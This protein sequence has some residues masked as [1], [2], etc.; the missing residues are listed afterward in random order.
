MPQEVEKLGQLPA[1]CQV[2]P[3]V[4]SSRSSST[5]SVQPSRVRWYSALQPTAPPPMTTTRAWLL[6]QH[7]VATGCARHA[8]AGAPDSTLHPRARGVI[9]GLQRGPRGNALGGDLHLVS[10]CG[11]P[12]GAHRCAAV[13]EVAET[14]R[15]TEGM[16]EHPGGDA[17][18]QLIVPPDRLVVIQQAIGAL[19][20]NRHESPP[21]ALRAPLAERLETDKA[22][23]LVPGDGEL[24]AGL[25]RCV[26]VADVVAPVPIRLFHAQAVQGMVARE[27]QSEGLTRTDDHVVYGL[28]KLGGDVQLVAQLSD[29]RDPARPY[30]RV[31]EIDDPG[32]SERKGG[33]GQ[34]RVGERREQLTTARA[35]EPQHRIPRG[36]V[37]CDG[38]GVRRNAATQP[39]EI[40]RLRRA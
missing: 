30:A 34:V 9:E 39:A 15:R 38:A 12:L 32:G 24:Q 16:A 22:P 4:S 6:M 13:G 28:R 29:I 27:A 11:D 21:H 8:P 5:T 3:A 7:T 25:E 33:R 1:A 19:E 2:E 36:H 17:S 40:A 18:D 31:A 26:L 10:A 23:G 20:R 37:E 35:H 14:E